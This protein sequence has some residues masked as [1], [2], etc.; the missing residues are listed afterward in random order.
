MTL[1][2]MLLGLQYSFHLLTNQIL[3]I[4]NYGFNSDIEAEGKEPTF[5]KVISAGRD[6]LGVRDW[7]VHTAVFKIDSQQGPTV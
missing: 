4:I 2:I 1:D 5:K 6:R 3:D 7:H